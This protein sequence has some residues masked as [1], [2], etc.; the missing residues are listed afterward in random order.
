MSGRV[1]KTIVLAAV[2]SSGFLAA[3]NAGTSDRDHWDRDHWDRERL[4][5]ERWE[6]RHDH[7]YDHGRD[8]GPGR[9][10]DRP[11]QVI[12]ERQPI[13]VQQAPRQQPVYMAPVMVAPVER[14]YAPPADPSVN[15][16]FSFPR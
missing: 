7:H 3:A 12:V 8:H 16:N 14:N 13:I 4:E 9:D 11:R 10:N 15:F 6:H 5:R 1:W 2:A